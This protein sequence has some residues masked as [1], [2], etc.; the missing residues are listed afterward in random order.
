MGGYV[1][2]QKLM[3]TPIVKKVTVFKHE[4]TVL[5]GTF[6]SS[7]HFPESAPLYAG[8]IGQNVTMPCKGFQTK[9]NS[10][11]TRIN[12]YYNCRSC[13]LEWSLLTHTELDPHI[14]LEGRLASV[15]LSN[16]A[17]TIHN[18]QTDAEGSYKCEY[19]GSTVDFIK[20]RIAGEF[21]V[22]LLH[23]AVTGLMITLVGHI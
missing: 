21:T 1:S 23:L 7:S 2:R 22:G 4:L 18:Y 10:T 6:N 9:R 12:W 3:F 19:I 17:L 11:M 5:V 20:L 8:V 13:G 16:G 14:D 15:S